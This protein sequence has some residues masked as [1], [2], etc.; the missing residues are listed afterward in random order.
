MIDTK[1][2]VVSSMLLAG[3]GAR[4]NYF[5]QA[6]VLYT[7]MSDRVMRLIAEETHFSY[8]NLFSLHRHSL[9]IS[10]F[11]GEILDLLNIYQDETL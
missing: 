2:S 9:L 5:V 11:F 4:L 6:I 1:A 3:G 8:T 10:D 7:G